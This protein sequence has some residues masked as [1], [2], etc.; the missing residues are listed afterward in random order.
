MREHKPTV[1]HL[2]PAMGQI[3]V[4]LC[5]SVAFPFFLLWILLDMMFQETNK[6]I[7]Q[8]SNDADSDI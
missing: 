5:L 3:L 1:T 7:C 4:S 2:T 6:V 8:F